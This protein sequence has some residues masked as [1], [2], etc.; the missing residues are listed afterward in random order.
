MKV[1]IIEDE[2]QAI[3][4]LKQE[5]RLNCPQ[6]IV[7]GE[8][9]TV[10]EGV[11]KIKKLKPDLIFLD[12]QLSDGLGFDILEKLD[13]INFKIIFTTAFSEY[14]L[15]AIKF[16]ALDYLLKPVNSKELKIAVAKS[17][18][19]KQLDLTSKLELVIKNQNSQI[20]NKKIALQTSEGL[21]I[22]EVSNIL[23]CSS[24]GNYTKMY[25]V[26]GKKILIS[27]TLKEL[28]KL[29]LS[30]NFAR[31]HHSHLI[32]INH[33]VSFINKDGGYV[34][35]NDKTTLPVSQ[36]KKSVLIKRLEELNNLGQL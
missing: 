14:A 19:Q 8:A 13:H 11:S 10:E 3:S 31:I 33:L 30:F 4:A 35:M 24:E 36:R 16:S 12:I 28:E 27:K 18:E 20:I 22:Y 6:L 7:A 34:I 32:N 23:K 29:L 25:F 5:L 15:R 9:Q 21:F 17:L 2:P 1:L 26:N